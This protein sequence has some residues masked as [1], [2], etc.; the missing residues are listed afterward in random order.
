[1]IPEIFKGLIIPNLL[2]LGAGSNDLEIPQLDDYNTWNRLLEKKLREAAVKKYPSRFI[3]SGGYFTI[4]D[5]FRDGQKVMIAVRDFNPRFEGEV[6]RE[7][8]VLLDGNVHYLEYFDPE[9]EDEILD[10]PE[11][12]PE[13]YWPNWRSSQSPAILAGSFYIGLR[14]S[15]IFDPE[16][17]KKSIHK[18]LSN[19][20]TPSESE[21]RWRGRLIDHEAILNCITETQNRINYRG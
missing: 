12:R 16:V 9:T 3:S 15:Q 17:T 21:V 7:A 2:R 6:H 13:K 14:R 18:M 19:P 1:M 11:E 20:G 5:F 4:G 10:N 8:V